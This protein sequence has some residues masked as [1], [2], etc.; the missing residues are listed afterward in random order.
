MLNRTRI[1][2][3]A[4]VPGSI[5]S[6]LG[7]WYGS[8]RVRIDAHSSCWL[9]T[10]LYHI[11]II[12]MSFYLQRLLCQASYSYEIKENIAPTP[13]EAPLQFLFQ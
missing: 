9:Q 1:G 6:I 7:S 4:P 3:L 12:I 2:M 8:V 10:W 13:L 11:I 5:K